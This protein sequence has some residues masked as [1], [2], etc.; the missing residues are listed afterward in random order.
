MSGNVT[1]LGNTAQ[2]SVLIADTQMRS[3]SFSQ[4]EQVVGSAA[5]PSATV[6]QAYTAGINK[7]IWY[8]PLTT[9]TAI[10]AVYTITGLPTNF[11]SL[12]TVTGHTVAVAS[13]TFSTAPIISDS[14][15]TFSGT[16][17]FSN[18]LSS[19]SP[20]FASGTAYLKVTVTFT[21]D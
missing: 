11:P 7:Y 18:P 14:H 21:L 12:Y 17:L 16:T 1:N 4:P 3:P 9:A 20:V 8:S 15:Q 6:T 13:A 5:S 19:T 10:T 2:A